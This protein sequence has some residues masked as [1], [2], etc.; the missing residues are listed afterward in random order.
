[1]TD[2][3]KF[4]RTS[5]SILTIIKNMGSQNTLNIIHNVFTDPYKSKTFL[6]HKQRN[7]NYKNAYNFTHKIDKFARTPSLDRHQST[8]RKLT[9]V[10]HFSF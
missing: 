4:A 6:N 1:M 9:L 10:A 7:S 2:Q 8:S 3:N 5:S